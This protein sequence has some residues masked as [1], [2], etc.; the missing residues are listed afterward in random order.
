MKYK[1]AID[2][3]AEELLSEQNDFL[4]LQRKMKEFKSLLF[5]ITQIDTE[6][7]SNRKEIQFENGIALGTTFAALCIDDI[8]R[9][10][11]YVRGVFEAVKEVANKKNTPVRI[12]YV[13]TGPFAVLILPLLAKYS[14]KEIQLTLLEVNENTISYLKRL[15]KEL[16]I[17]D[18]IERIICEDASK[19]EIPEEIK[20]DIILSETMQ[21]GLVKEQQLPIMLNLVNQLDKDIIMIPTNI[22][23]D[24]ALYS[25]QVDLT[26]KDA[27]VPNYKVL[28]PVLDFDKKFIHSQAEKNNSSKENKRFELCKRLNFRNEIDKL[29]DKIAI[30]T[31]IHVY[32]NEWIHLNSIGL[33]IPKF[34]VDLQYI[35]P[36]LKEI[37]LDFVI[38]ENP[39]FDFEL[40]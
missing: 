24:L 6:E 5:N 17:N 4:S 30:L 26:M 14:A 21:H 25:T 19:Y 2:K 22:K 9:T 13:G 20:A 8:I 3:I 12:L 34:L 7:E 15:I 23:L 40:N 37:S 36:Q 38:K 16:D 27:E 29:Y 18:Y 35:D 39:D 28:K 10:R 31:T 1:E 33:T 32:G 11:Q